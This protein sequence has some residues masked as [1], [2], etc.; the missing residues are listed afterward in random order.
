MSARSGV[1]EGTLRVWEARHAF[2][3]PARLPSGHRRYSELD[4]VRVRAVVDAR[5][6]GHPLRMAI[7][8]AQA[9][10]V[11][12]ELVGRIALELVEGVHESLREPPPSPRDELRIALALSSRMVLYATG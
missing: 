2:P 4:L 8:R 9:A 1:G 11:C 5:K 12:S 6:H 7:D 10:R 3:V